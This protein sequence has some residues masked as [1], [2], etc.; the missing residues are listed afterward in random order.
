MMLLLPIC[1]HEV[2]VGLVLQLPENIED[3]YKVVAQIEYLLTD[4]TAS[5]T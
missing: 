2:L 1:S 4:I 3:Y 5:L